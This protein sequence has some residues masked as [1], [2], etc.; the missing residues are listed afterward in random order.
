MSLDF[1]K[2]SRYGM[3]RFGFTTQVAGGP[4]GPAIK[5]ETFPYHDEPTIDALTEC[6]VNVS[7]D[8]ARIAGLMHR[9]GGVVLNGIEAK[10]RPR[11]T[12][13]LRVGRDTLFTYLERLEAPNYLKEAAK[14]LANE[15]VS[16]SKK[17]ENAQLKMVCGCCFGGVIQAIQQADADQRPIIAVP[18]PSHG[19][20]GDY[21]SEFEQRIQRE[22]PAHLRQALVD[23]EPKIEEIAAMMRRERERGV[24]IADALIA[25]TSKTAR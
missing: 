11:V 19:L 18:G 7:A 9:D 23:L 20:P 1:D 12:E 13:I 3:D 8:S 21:R 17:Y 10:A 4:E 22:F 5:I 14:A 6:L 24:A 16:D 15:M 25:E 2:L